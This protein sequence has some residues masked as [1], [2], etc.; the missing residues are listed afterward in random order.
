MMHLVP[1]VV[2]NYGT[3]MKDGLQKGWQVMKKSEK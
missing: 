3:M 1:V 2:R